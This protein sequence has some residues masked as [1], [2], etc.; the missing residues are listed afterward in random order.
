MKTIQIFISSVT[1][2]F[3]RLR[4]KIKSEQFSP[5]S[6][7]LILNMIGDK[8]GG[9]DSRG[10][11][12]ASLEHTSDADIFILLL[13]ETYGTV[14]KGQEKSYTHLEYEKAIQERKNILVFPIGDI[15][16]N[17]KG[18]E[19][20]DNKSFNQW[21]NA[22]LNNSN[23]HTTASA[24]SSD[25]NIDKIYKY[26]NKELHKHIAQNYNKNKQNKIVSK[27]FNPTSLNN[28]KEHCIIFVHDIFFDKKPFINKQKKYF[29]EYLRTSIQE[30]FSFDYEFKYYQNKLTLHSL[31]FLTNAIRLDY[32]LEI[33]AKL[34]FT[35]YKN[36]LEE[37][38]KTVS[39]VGH[40]IGG[41]IAQQTIINLCKKDIPFKG[42]YIS[43]ATPH[44]NLDKIK[45]IKHTTLFIKQNKVELNKLIKDWQ[46]YKNR[47]IRR[48]YCDTTD[49][50]I[51]S[52]VAFPN[53]LEEHKCIITTNKKDS[54]S[55]PCQNNSDLIMNLNIFLKT[56]ILKIR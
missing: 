22:I 3:V 1:K 40:G 25:D 33:L 38:Y 52:E 39:F 51:S 12:D 41:I 19:Y 50:I 9:A 42:L 30:T 16:T 2:E 34:L 43:L 45:K 13:G 18:I 15:Y 11:L 37:G 4:E 14:P 49:M 29:D 36:K 7:S 54:I 44:N 56:G 46:R 20:S 48:Y 35:K 47:I 53:D 24:F 28:T 6:D 32:C 27:S 17:P 8:G 21:Q 5:S 31:P 23:S 26:I 10:P 55:K